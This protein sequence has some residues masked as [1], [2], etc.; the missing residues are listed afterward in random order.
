MILRGIEVAKSYFE[1]PD[2]T[3]SEGSNPFDE[4]LAEPV[5]YNKRAWRQR[6]LISIGRPGC[7]PTNNAMVGKTSL[8]WVCMMIC[9]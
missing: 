7:G 1:I 8:F 2:W 5:C 4:T 9:N 3:T 6:L